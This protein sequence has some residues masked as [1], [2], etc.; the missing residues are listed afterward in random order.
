M[1]FN[2]EQL[3]TLSAWEENF[4]TA[5]KAD[6]ARNPGRNG[7]RVIYDI[8]TQMTGDKRRFND[9]CNH[10]ILSLLKDCGRIYFH[11]KEEMTAKHKAAKAVEQEKTT[12][13]IVV[14]HVSVKTKRPTK[15]SKD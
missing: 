6:W 15:K 11:D 3:K 14:K 7:L 2:E 13:E 8:Y 5:V 12:K 9:N 1:T 4:R 10:C